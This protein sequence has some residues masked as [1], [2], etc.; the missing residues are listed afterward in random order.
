MT[1]EYLSKY[2]DVLLNNGY[3]DDEIIKEDFYNSVFYLNFFKNYIEQMNEFDIN[4][5]DMYGNLRR[6][7]KLNNQF[8]LPQNHFLD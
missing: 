2:N 8:M 5:E 1:E 6:V 3:S 7:M 4:E